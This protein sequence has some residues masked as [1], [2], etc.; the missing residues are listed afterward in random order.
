MLPYLVT[1]LLLPIVLL[2]ICR[3]QTDTEISG[4][5]ENVRFSPARLESNHSRCRVGCNLLELLLLGNRLVL[6]AFLV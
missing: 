2:L 3:I 5:V 4:F 6:A 1:R